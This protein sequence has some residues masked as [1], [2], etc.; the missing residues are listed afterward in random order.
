ML[1]TLTQQ[2]SSVLGLLYFESEIH[3]R[4]EPSSLAKHHSS[5]GHSNPISVSDEI[6]SETHTETSSGW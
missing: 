6:R 2:L 1:L 4:G 3:L 5:N